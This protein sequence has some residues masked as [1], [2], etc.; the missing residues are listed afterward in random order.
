MSYRRDSFEIGEWYHCYTRSVER[1]SDTKIIFRTPTDSE[2]F[3]Q[4]LYL[5]NSV[6]P[7][8][9]S[10]LYQPTHADIMKMDIK[11]PIVSIGAYCIM[12]THF[13]F[14]MK[15]K[16]EGGISKLMQTVG[17][18]FSMYYNLKHKRV[19]N[20]FVKPFRSRHVVDDRYFQHVVNYIHLNPA[21]L[22]ESRWKYGI[23]NNMAKLENSLKSYRF[24]SLNDYI[25]IKRS[26]S[27]ILDRD[28]TTLVNQSDQSF[29]E[30]LTETSEFYREYEQNF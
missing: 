23:V 2:R 14:L 1:S 24:S 6:K 17:T 21:E 16:V 3:L 30:L 15:E 22:Y 4:A 10:D 12:P 26:E 7:I 9:R 5:A 28:V 29:S 25:G 13:H 20:V 27:V 18:A 11:E 8:R 19:G